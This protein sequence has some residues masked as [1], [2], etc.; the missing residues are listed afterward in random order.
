VY[1][2]EKLY[3]MCET[4]RA[5]LQGK[6]GVGRVIARPFVGT[7]KGHFQRTGGRR[8]FSM[9]PMSDTILNVMKKNGFDVLGVGKIEDIFAHRGLTESNH[10]AG[11]PACI[12]ATLE[13]MLKERW[14][15]LLFVN[16]VD[17]DMMFGHRRDVK[18]FAKSLEEFDEKLPEI[19]RAL[20][21]DG[22]LMITADH[23]CDPETASTDHSREYVP[24]LVWGN[25]IRP[26]NLGTR[27]TFA[28]L[29]R[30]VCDLLGVDGSALPGES[31]AA[32]LTEGAR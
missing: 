7:G 31:L 23:G 29:G 18:G 12:D 1:P 3:E 24:L 20:G 27:P 28:V 8:D 17:T 14:R 6:H 19:M 9:E 25:Q 32:E 22:L 30:T 5:Q 2:V 4:A 16:L 11:N 21:D 10:A 15:G 26:Q 13:F